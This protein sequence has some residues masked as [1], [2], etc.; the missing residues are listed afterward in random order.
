MNHLARSLKNFLADN[1][2]DRQGLKRKENDWLKAQ[3]HAPTARIVVLWQTKSLFASE[4]SPEPVFVNAEQLGDLLTGVEP[5]FLGTDGDTAYFAI[6]LP[7]EQAPASVTDLG[8]FQDLRFRPG[9]DSQLGAIIGYA[10]GIIYWHSRHQFCSDC[11]SQ[12]VSR[13]GGFVRG[14]LSST[15]GKSHFPRT[16]MAIIVIVHG[17]DAEGAERCMLARQPSWPK[18][19]YSVVA[20][21]V[22]PGESL[23]A[24]VA[25]EVKEE[26]NI[27]VGSV[28]YHS[29]QPWPFPGSLMLGYMA[30]ATS[31]DIATLDQELEHARWFTHKE[32]K[33][34]IQNGDLRLPPSQAISYRLIETWFDAGNEGT[35][36]EITVDGDF[37]R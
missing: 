37:L 14:C 15:C 5:I 3:L 12:T 7:G 17:R 13:E 32:L 4:H 19:R 25:R 33:Q 24:A 9:L 28:E 10:K 29:S 21:F 34:A 23:E 20:G 26:T 30:E 1:P 36:R 2:L 8:S 16:D 11:G 31:H 18:G 6:D 22:E 35:L 27:D